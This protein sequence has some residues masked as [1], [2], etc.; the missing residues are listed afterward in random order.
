M[1]PE[2]VGTRAGDDAG[3]GDGDGG[4]DG[5]GAPRQLVEV[6]LL[7]LPIANYVDS[8]RHHDELFREFALIIHRPAR[9]GDDQV[10]VRLLALVE[11]LTARF[12]GFTAAPQGELL[13]AVQRGDDSIDLTYLVPPE[14]REASVRLRDLLREA[15]RYCRRGE[16]L[17]LAP[18]PDSVAFREWYLEEFVAQIDGAQ[19]TPWTR[20]VAPTRG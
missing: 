7:G 15:D 10:P 19:P 4:G 17:T 1:T 6:R 20:R 18:P 3:D 14:A 9:D 8:A 5:D 16:L 12:S 11:E 2:D 13:A